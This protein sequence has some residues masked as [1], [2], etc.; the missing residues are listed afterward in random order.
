MNG[1]KKFKC[2]LRTLKNLFVNF[3]KI[4][5]NYFKGMDTN[6]KNKVKIHFSNMNFL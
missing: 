3:C 2:K 4:Q 5:I 6:C 1:Y